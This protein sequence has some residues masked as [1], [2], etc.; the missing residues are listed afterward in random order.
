MLKHTFDVGTRLEITADIG[1][2]VVRALLDG[3]ARVCLIHEDIARDAGLPLKKTQTQL[4]GAFSHGAKAVKRVENLWCS[5]SGHVASL[6]AYTAKFA[7]CSLLLGADFLN[8]MG[9]VLDYG[10]RRVWKEIDGRRVDID[11]RTQV[12]VAHL[13]S[14]ARNKYSRVE[15]SVSRDALAAVVEEKASES[16]ISDDSN[17]V[18]AVD[19]ASEEALV[20]EAPAEEIDIVA[21]QAWFDAIRAQKET[22]TVDVP[23]VEPK[24][25]EH[26]S[27]LMAMVSRFD[28]QLIIP[29]T[30]LTYS[31][32]ELANFDIKEEFLGLIPWDESLSQYEREVIGDTLWRYKDVVSKHE[33]DIGLAPDIV[34]D[35]KTTDDF[36]ENFKYQGQRCYSLKDKQ[37]QDDW[38]ENL[39][40]AGVIEESSSPISCPVLVVRKDNKKARVLVDYTQLNRFLKTSDD[41]YMSMKDAFDS[42]GGKKYFSAVDLT[43]AFYSIPIKPEQRWMT[44]F[45]THNKLLQMCRLGMGISVSPRH[46]A[47]LSYKVTDG[48]NDFMTSYIDDI[49]ISSS[50]F[51]E[52]MEHFEKLLQRLRQFNLKIKVTKCQLFTKRLNYLGHVISENGLEIPKD[53]ISAIL[54]V[55]PPRDLK[56]LRSWIGVANFNR[57]H[58]EN[59]DKYLGP[60]HELT[61]KDVKFVWGEEHQK[62]FDELK[63][64]MTRTS[65]LAF[66]D[67]NCEKLILVDACD[68][69]CGGGITQRRNGKIEVIAYFNKRLSPQE[70][71]WS[72]IEKELYSILIATRLYYR[73]LIDKPF[74]IYTDHKPLLVL[75]TLRSPRN[76]RLHRWA[77]E[78]SMFN[79]EV[80]YIKSE[81]NV[82]PDSVSRL[83]YYVD[84][85]ANDSQR[86][87][88]LDSSTLVKRLDL[89]ARENEI[90]EKDVI[91]LLNLS[92][93]LFPENFDR[94]IKS[95]QEEDPFCIAIKTAIETQNQEFPEILKKFRVVSGVVYKRARTNQRDPTILRVVIPHVLIPKI[96]EIFHNNSGHHGVQKTEQKLVDRYFFTNIREHVTAHV[97]QCEQFAKARY[98]NKL[99]YGIPHT[100]G[101]PELPFTTLHW[102]LCG[103][104]QKSASGN[105]YY[106]VCIDR[107][108]RYIIAGPVRDK[109][110]GQYIKFM[111]E[112]MEEHNAP[113]KLISDRDTAFTS[114]EFKAFLRGLHIEHH[115]TATFYGQSNG[116]AESCH[117]RILAGLRRYCNH[118]SS[119]WDVVLKSVVKSLNHSIHMITGYSA[120]YLLHGFNPINAF[121]RQFK[122][123]LVKEYPQMETDLRN[124][125]NSDKTL[126]TARQDA[127]QRIEAAEEKWCKWR[128]TRRTKA[129]FLLYDLVYALDKTIDLK[130][131]NKKLKSLH[132]G[133]YVIVAEPISGSYH[134]VKIKADKRGGRRTYV[135]NA[136]LLM[137]YFGPV[138]KGYYEVVASAQR[139][140][141]VPNRE[142]LE[143]PW[144]VHNVRRWQRIL[145][146]EDRADDHIPFE[147]SDSDSEPDNSEPPVSDPQSDEVL[148]EQPVSE[149]PITDELTDHPNMDTHLTQSGTTVADTQFNSQFSENRNLFVD[150]ESVDSFDGF[151][152]TQREL[153]STHN[154][155]VNATEE[156]AI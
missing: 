154:N 69:A 42:F 144:E 85:E 148:T 58:I 64:A 95:F 109:T 81:L 127:K 83:Q 10:Q 65:C 125:T 134:I 24:R 37:A 120:Y 49:A 96:L 7:E 26:C 13:W 3:G 147:E 36:P 111:T 70:R 4:V 86:V 5:L 20:N 50:S 23:Q 82:F 140:E 131:K 135:V 119:D 79:F 94:D 33:F 117:R 153:F 103:P 34:A 118:T 91:N 74:V 139:G 92:D 130:N 51:E 114:R 68:G 1:G 56:A 151:I 141:Y 105:K 101:V 150:P 90:K 75:N 84:T 57:H 30:D 35:I 145:R 132:A 152:P 72:V 15:K 2:R 149:P 80:R 107:L 52:H 123:Q 99:P 102:D 21:V 46:M 115:K 28:D 6:E 138:P 129:P 53:R 16:I 48:Y 136:N 87:E 67:E 44:A 55:P 108:T 22:A 89:T 142:E 60:L 71:L 146:N 54:T 97:R 155:A 121:E 112:I 93:D 116:L 38:V 25:E 76:L 113:V 137:P 100:I 78:L 106:I 9:L 45:K 122:L 61:R 31:S 32:E 126:E 73:W 143:K 77:I 104:L 41:P 12:P 8:E 29:K 17:D 59:I 124:E 18:N 88:V 63:K 110:A 66:P 40:K 14:G 98:P 27:D 128:E 43:M 11:I 62:C 47:R 133:P 19:T 156:L 39:M